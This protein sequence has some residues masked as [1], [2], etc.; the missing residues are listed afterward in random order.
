MPNNPLFNQLQGNAPVN[1][2]LQR[3]LQFRNGFNGNPQQIV[4][5]M[6]NSGRLSQAQFNRYAQQANELYEQFKPYM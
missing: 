1:P 3:F 2:M 6:L 5:N 4:Q